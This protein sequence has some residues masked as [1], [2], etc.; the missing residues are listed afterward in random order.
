M[1]GVLKLPIFILKG[2]A[3][4]H[5]SGITAALDVV[6]VAPQAITCF[7]FNNAREMIVPRSMPIKAIG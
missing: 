4:L 1:T 7:R 5:L 3:F 2:T 6:V